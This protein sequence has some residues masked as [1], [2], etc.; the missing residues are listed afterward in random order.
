MLTQLYVVT[1][2]FNPWRWRTRGIHYQN[3]RQHVRNT[4]MCKLYAGELAFG[5]RPFE[6]TTGD[7]HTVDDGE[8]HEFQYRTRTELWH[9]ERMLNRLI[10][11]LPA[12]WE[13]VAWVDADVQFARPDW[14][15]E[16]VHR[17]Q[18]HDAVQMF[19]HCQNLD[20][21]YDVLD[22]KPPRPGFAYAW[23]EGLQPEL[24]ENERGYYSKGWQL[25]HPGFAF[26]FR[27][28]AFERLGG[29]LDV[30]ALGSGDFFMCLALAGQLEGHLR[31]GMSAGYREQLLLWADRARRHVR[32]NMGYVPGLLLH[33]FHGARRDRRY[34]E[35]AEI[36]DRWAF[37]PEF[38][39]K[40]DSQGLWQW[41]ERC[42]E[43]HYAVRDYFR[44]RREDHPSD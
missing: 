34:N 7:H 29:F 24:A 19:S 31:A 15:L 38:D 32:R 13:Y 37:D 40:P 12:D 4:G 41:T 22:N 28:D 9:K 2:L 6:Y 35:R 23:S 27:R 5:Q 33:A 44:T 8:T 17:L 30:A 10:Q 42:P 14:A 43:L 3:F 18:H 1:P 20:S 21:Y 36:L 39:L 11:E 25:G 26:A 16:T